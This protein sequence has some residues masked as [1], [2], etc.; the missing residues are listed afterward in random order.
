MIRITKNNHKDRSFGMFLGMMCVVFFGYQYLYAGL[1]NYTAG[2]IG[3]V[4]LILA[5]SVPLLFYPFRGLMEIIGHFM[6]IA[7]TYVLLTVIFIFLFIP[8]GLI[9]KIMGKDGLKRKWDSK[10]TSYW[11]ERQESKTSSMKN[12]F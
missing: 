2:S 1:L 12:Q 4:L 10:G 8:I 6:G 11:V 5:F 3:L 7:N 9:L